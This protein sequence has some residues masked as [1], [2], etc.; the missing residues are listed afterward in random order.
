MYR[1]A[2]GGGVKLRVT[3]FSCPKTFG[4]DCS[5]CYQNHFQTVKLFASWEANFLSGN[6]VSR[7]EL[8]EEH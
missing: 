5:L 1:G 8:T 7:G 3:L 2:G 4:K 6:N